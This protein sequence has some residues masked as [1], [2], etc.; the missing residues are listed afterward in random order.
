MAYKLLKLP[1]NSAYKNL[2]IVPDGLLNF[3]P[4]EALITKKSATTNFAKMNYLLNDYNIGYQNSAQFYLEANRAKRNS[5]ATV[6]GIFP[7]FTKRHRKH[8]I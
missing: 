4:F 7:I 8:Q 1:V 6:L 3:L 2:L 5:V